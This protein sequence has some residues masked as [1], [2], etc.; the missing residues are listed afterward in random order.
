MTYFSSLQD[1]WDSQG[2][3]VIEVRTNGKIKLIKLK[4]DN[5]LPNVSKKIDESTS[6]PVRVNLQR[7]RK[8]PYQRR[9]SCKIERVQTI[10]ESR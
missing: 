5:R 6:I 1:F 10:N 7:L 4:Y 3:E 8:V 2:A 9:R